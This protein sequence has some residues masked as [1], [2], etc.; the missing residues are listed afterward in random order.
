MHRRDDPA[1]DFQQARR[2]RA[3]VDD[4]LDIEL[5][6]DPEAATEHLGKCAR[7]G[8]SHEAQHRRLAL[9]RFG[10]ESWF[11][12]ETR[13]QLTAKRDEG[14]RPAGTGVVCLHEQPGLTL[15]AA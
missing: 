2:T 7:F 13:Q 3:F 6:G 8:R 9:D 4:E 15:L 12:T 11:P 10:G 5:S 1:I 14:L